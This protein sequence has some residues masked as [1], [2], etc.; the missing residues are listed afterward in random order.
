MYNIILKKGREKSVRNYHPWIFS[1]AIAKIEGGPGPGDIVRV[2][3]RQGGFLSYGYYNP[4]PQISV[5]LLDWDE[6]AVIERDWWK[7][8]IQAAINRRRVYFKDESETNAYRLIYSECD[9]LPGLIVDKYADKLVLQSLTAGT[10]KVKQVVAEILVEL[11][12]PSAIFERSDSESRA[13]EGLDSGSGVLYGA[14]TASS[15]LVIIENGLK[16]RV[17]IES[18]QKTGFYLDQGN[19]RLKATQYAQDLDILDCFCHTGAFSVYALHAGAKS[20]ALIDSSA[21]SLAI[22]QENLELNGIDSERAEIMRGDVFERLRQFRDEGRK[23]DMVI[24]DPPKFAKS[25][26]HLKKALSAYKDINLLGTM[27]LKPEG[28]LV[29]FTCSG[30]VDYDTLRTVLF[31]ASVDSGRNLQII[32]NLGQGPDHPELASFPEG[33][34]LHGIIGRV[35]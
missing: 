10:E 24:L 34:Y 19:N 23:F 25:K 17:D 8:K 16:F 1:G 28:F 31:W 22:A 2:N 11:L 12:N 21:D 5:R 13:L 29:S 33:S 27:L 15:P 30:A 7:R 6:S 35:I 18:G 9:G 3:D 20:S 14:K 32:E 26:S 4:K